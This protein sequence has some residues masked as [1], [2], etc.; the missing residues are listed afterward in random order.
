[1]HRVDEIDH[2]S[3]TLPAFI[4]SILFKQILLSSVGIG[5]GLENLDSFIQDL[6]DSRTGDYT[7]AAIYTINDHRP[8]GLA[9]KFVYDFYSW[10]DVNQIIKAFNNTDLNEFVLC[11]D[12]Y[13]RHSALEEYRTV[14]YV[15]LVHELNSCFKLYVFCAKTSKVIVC[16]NYGLDQKDDNPA[17]HQDIQDKLKID[18][19]NL[20]NSNF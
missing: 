16:G 17:K 11:P 6:T 3:L 15:S 2:F 20:I 19:S 4:C 5:S 13:T 8:V 18:A 9:G 14:S 12:K 1:M 10:S 7:S